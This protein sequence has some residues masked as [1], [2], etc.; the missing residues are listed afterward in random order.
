M[1]YCFEDHKVKDSKNTKLVSYNI[2]IFRYF[3]NILG[4]S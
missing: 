1:I 2:N 3:R 4:S